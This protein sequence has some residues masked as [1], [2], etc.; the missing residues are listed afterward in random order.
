MR[1]ARRRP[2]GQEGGRPRRALGGFLT[3]ACGLEGSDVG[4]LLGYSDI[5]EYGLIDIGGLWGT[6]THPAAPQGHRP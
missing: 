1:L 5:D 4:E 3:H 6:L 2:A